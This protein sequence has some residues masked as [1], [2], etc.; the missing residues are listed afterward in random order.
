MGLRHP[1]MS[2]DPHL[3]WVMTIIT[4]NTNELRHS[5]THIQAKLVLDRDLVNLR[6]AMNL[7]RYNFSKLRSPLNVI[8]QT[9]IELTFENFYQHQRHKGSERRTK[10]SS[11]FYQKTILSLFFAYFSKKVS[12]VRSTRHCMYP[13]I[14]L[15]KW[16]LMIFGRNA[17]LIRPCRMLGTLNRI[18]WVC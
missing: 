18:T 9:T 7:V 13:I 11:C 14:F 15:A 6:R 2:Y 10:G 1:V 17:C 4:I 8:C 3:A 16:L 5:Y 12:S